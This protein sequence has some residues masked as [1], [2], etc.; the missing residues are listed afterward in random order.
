LLVD[1]PKLAGRQEM[2]N[3][4]IACVLPLLSVSVCLFFL[5]LRT[6][7]KVKLLSLSSVEQL[8]DDLE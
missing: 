2:V 1:C 3:C 7:H 8:P 4:L 5:S 6:K